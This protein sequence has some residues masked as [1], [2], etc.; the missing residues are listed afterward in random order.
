MNRLYRAIMIILACAVAGLLQDFQGVSSA[1]VA[2]ESQNQKYIVNLTVRSSHNAELIS[3]LDIDSPAISQ[4]LLAAKQETVTDVL[5]LTD[6]YVTLLQGG[7]NIQARL[8]KSG[9]V[10]DEAA[11][12]R[13]VLPKKAADSLL[14]AAEALRK[15]HYGKLVSW[16]VAERMLPRKSKFS[17]TDLETGLTFKVQRRAG[18]DH[19]DVQPL[20]K[21]DSKIM[22]Q[23]Y[24][25]NW[26]WKRRAILVQSGNEWLA[27][28]MNG[29]PHGGDGIPDNDFSGHFCVHYAGSSTHR[30]DQ[31]DLAHQLMVY[32]A[33]GSLRSFLDAAS[34]L[35]LA[36]SVVEAMD[37]QDS[38]IL[39]QASE[40][41]AKE[42]FEGLVQEMKSMSYIRFLE[43]KKAEKNKLDD[44]GSNE[45]LTDEVKL[46]L[47]FQ[48]HGGSK[49]SKA[50]TFIFKRDSVQSPWRM[51]DIV[52]K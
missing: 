49:R 44:S 16:E 39:R 31:P 26:S 13:L 40:G 50:Y 43:Q 47:E 45:K 25:G 19:A 29:M 30:S 35:A 24:D 42:K 15:Q 41:I 20:T 12:K 7:H 21:K 1:A 33:A 22:K 37:H 46:P 18:E 4:A 23:I 14:H 52:T 51:E 6:V 36:K 48:K 34:P 3:R 27:A 17:I 38:E 2:K 11:W 10:V 32:K 5:S 9:N 28:S 8:E